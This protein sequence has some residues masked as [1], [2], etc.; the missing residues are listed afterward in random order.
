MLI[1][2]LLGSGWALD[3]ALR[4][5]RSRASLSTAL[6][7]VLGDYI[8]ASIGAGPAQMLQLLKP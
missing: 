6:S 8:P 1:Q 2:L 4:R 5:L 7:G 3:Y